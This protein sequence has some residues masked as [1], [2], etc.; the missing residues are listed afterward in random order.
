[1]LL[2]FLYRIIFNYIRM[3][4]IDEPVSCLYRELKKT[5]NLG[6]GNNSVRFFNNRSHASIDYC[7][8]SRG[9]P[10]TLLISQQ[11]KRYAEQIN[12]DRRETV[13]YL[14]VVRSSERPG[15]RTVIQTRIVRRAC[16]LIMHFIVGLASLMQVYM[17]PFKV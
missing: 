3:C 9:K 1:M 14:T 5:S 2:D 11:C 17:L 12:T 4:T 7:T 8:I 6:H 16:G 10:N 15:R 13:C